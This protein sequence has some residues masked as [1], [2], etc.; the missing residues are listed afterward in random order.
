MSHIII[1]GQEP[2]LPSGAPEHLPGADLSFD[3]GDGKLLESIE[4]VYASQWRTDLARGPGWARPCRLLD[5]TPSW[6]AIAH[7]C[8]QGVHAGMVQPAFACQHAV[9]QDPIHPCGLVLVPPGF[10]LCRTCFGLLERKR[11][12]LAYELFF[13][14]HPCLRDT[15]NRLA[16]LD[17]GLFVD[18]IKLGRK[19]RI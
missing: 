8:N 18:L 5:G 11:F 19:A 2:K 1:P 13:Q 9:H 17:P 15:A 4:D 7:K 14:C 12:K 6:F 10:Y 16:T 3:P